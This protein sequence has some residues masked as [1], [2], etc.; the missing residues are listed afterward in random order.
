MSPFAKHIAEQVQSVVEG[1]RPGLRRVYVVVAEYAD[2]LESTHPIHPEEP[3]EREIADSGGGAKGSRNQIEDLRLDEGLSRRRSGEGAVS[4]V[5]R[6]RRE[7][8]RVELKAKEWAPMTGLSVNEIERAMEQGAIE[9]RAKPNGRDHGARIIS[10]DTILAYL[11]EVAAVERGDIPQP[12]WWPAVR[13]V[14]K[15]AA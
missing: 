15:M 14:G 10:A 7:S 12:H 6:L 9:Y 11:T 5:Q 1:A 4:Y 13:S 8:G 3:D 2:G